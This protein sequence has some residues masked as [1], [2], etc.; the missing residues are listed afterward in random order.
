MIEITF[1]GGNYVLKDENKLVGFQSNIFDAMEMASK[2]T[3]GGSFIIACRVPEALKG[4]KHF[5]SCPAC[6]TGVKIKGSLNTSDF[7][8][9]TKDEYTYCPYC[10]KHYIVT[11]LPEP[12]RPE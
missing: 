9:N 5:Y 11:W 3:D 7:E 10:E 2:A 6:G 4:N 8:V 12:F 1:S